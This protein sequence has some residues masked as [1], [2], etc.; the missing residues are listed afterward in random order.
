MSSRS[1]LMLLSV[2]GTSQSYGG[3]PEGLPRRR[4]ADRERSSAASLKDPGDARSCLFCSE[5]SGANWMVGLRSD[6]R[7][8]HEL[9]DLLST[10]AGDGDL[11]GPF[12]RLIA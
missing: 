5:A 11:G 9:A 6:G 2:N 3:I 7:A 1:S 8:G 12:Q 4:L 10:A